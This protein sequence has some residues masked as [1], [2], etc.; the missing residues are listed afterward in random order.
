[1]KSNKEASETRFSPAQKLACMSVHQLRIQP[2]HGVKI[3]IFSPA[4]ESENAVASAFPIWA[5]EFYAYSHSSLSQFSL[6]LTSPLRIMTAS[7]HHLSRSTV[8]RGESL[9]LS[10]RPCV[11]EPEI[12]S[13]KGIL[14]LISDSKEK[15]PFISDGCFPHSLLRTFRACDD[16]FPGLEL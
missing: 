7:F 6:P 2:K 5:Y 14:C 9:Q 16:Q 3:S 1:M 13:T 8:T 4:R 11:R 10:V 15:L 12:L